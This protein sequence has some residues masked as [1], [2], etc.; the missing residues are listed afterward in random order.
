M[1]SNGGR[2]TSKNQKQKMKFNLCRMEDDLGDDLLSGAWCGHI[3]GQQRD[4]T[5]EGSNAAAA[6]VTATASD[7]A[8]PSDIPSSGSGNTNQVV[9]NIDISRENL[10]V[11]GT[12]A[13]M[14][15]GQSMD[16][17]VEEEGNIMGATYL[18]CKAARTAGMTQPT[19]NVGIDG[20]LGGTTLVRED[21]VGNLDYGGDVGYGQVLQ[22]IDDY[23]SGWGSQSESVHD[24]RPPHNELHRM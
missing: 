7:A 20:E 10:P 24:V 23:F 11:P 3:P 22:G 21:R 19:T 16:Y 4:T 14:V 13:S 9:I 12:S 5:T 2:Y 17:M 1:I 8:V 18:R 15:S 6:A